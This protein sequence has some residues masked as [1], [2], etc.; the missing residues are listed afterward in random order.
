M[1]DDLMCHGVIAAP[2]RHV[3]IEH[4][5]PIVPKAVAEAVWEEASVWLDEELP[6]AWIGELTERANVIYA[7][8][9]RFRHVIRRKG[10]TG[11]ECL[12]AFTRHWLAALLWKH[13]RELHARLP[14]S[15]NVGRSLPES[16]PRTR[17]LSA[18]S[19]HAQNLSVT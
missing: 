5:T 15:Y 6:R 18:L 8:N 1:I 17:K 14:D 7:H 9:H 16:P 12:W 11:R 19:N 3:W 4:D 10:N 13:R 2:P